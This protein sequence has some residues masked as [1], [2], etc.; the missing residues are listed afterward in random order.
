MAGVSARRALQLLPLFRG[1]GR[2]E[3]D[4]QRREEKRLRRRAPSGHFKT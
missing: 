1:R 3:L 2:A 4:E